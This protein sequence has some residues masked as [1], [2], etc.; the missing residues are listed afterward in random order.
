VNAAYIGIFSV[1]QHRV[2]RRVADDGSCR[3]VWLA[4]KLAAA[5]GQVEVLGPAPDDAMPFGVQ[6]I[7]HATTRGPRQAVAV[8]ESLVDG[9][10][11]AFHV[12]VS[13]GDAAAAA[14]ALAPRLPGMTE[15]A[16]AAL[17]AMRSPG[18]LFAASPFVIKGLDV[19]QAPCCSRPAA[20]LRAHAS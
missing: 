6:I 18:P 2:T 3:P 14:A 13:A 5:A 15:T 8:S 4:M 7:V 17:A 1:G 19:E 10:I 11:A 16:I 9:T 20:K 12:C